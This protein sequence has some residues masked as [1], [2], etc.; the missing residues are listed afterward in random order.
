MR[1]DRRANKITMII[2]FAVSRGRAT[3]LSL[4]CFLALHSI[5]PNAFA[6][7]VQIYPDHQLVWGVAFSLDDQ[8]VIATGQDGAV[9][10]WDLASCGLHSVAVPFPV[11]DNLGGTTITG[12]AVSPTKS[13]FATAMRDGSVRLWEVARDPTGRGIIKEKAVYSGPP[14]NKGMRSVTFSPDGTLLAAAGHDPAIYVWRADGAGAPLHIL[15]GHTAQIKVIVKQLAPELG[16]C[17]A[18]SSL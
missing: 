16:W 6:E 7:S 10:M 17:H 18:G 5:E 12:I 14:S 8:Y 1:T 2:T 11:G 13:K 3:I 15:K 4:F 9:L